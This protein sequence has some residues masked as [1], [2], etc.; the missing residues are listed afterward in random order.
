V[1]YSI[2][3]DASVLTRAFKCPERVDFVL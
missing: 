3:G 2:E 1:I